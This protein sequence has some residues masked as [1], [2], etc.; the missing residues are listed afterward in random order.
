GDI[1]ETEVQINPIQENENLSYPNLK[2]EKGES[3]IAQGEWTIRLEVGLICQCYPPSSDG[4]ISLYRFFVISLFRYIVIPLY[5][6][7]VIPK[8]RNPEKLEH[9]YESTY[10]E[11]H[12]PVHAYNLL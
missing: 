12:D 5:R 11:S 8:S 3:P 7:I 9:P 6:H 1:S 4:V 10:T 2:F